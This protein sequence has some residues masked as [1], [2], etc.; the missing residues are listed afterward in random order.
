MEIIA[1]SILNLL[2][3]HR[4]IFSFLGALFEGTYVM[5][6]AGV[7]YKFGYFKLWGVML[8]LL[9]GY[10]LNGIMFYLIGRM[11]GNTALEKWGSRFHLTKK[12][13][14]KLENYFKKHSIKTIF[15]TRITYGL[16]GPTMIIAG[17]FKMKWKKFI[18]VNLISSLVWVLVIFGLGYVFGSSFKALGE[19]TRGIAIGAVV[20][21]FI[22]TVSISVFV[23]FWIKH[24]TKIKFLKRLENN[25]FQFFRKIGNLIN[26]LINKNS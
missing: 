16:S 18:T 3:E 20:A 25:R 10:V 6:L 12:I 19:I 14:E 7:L 11:G 9:G 22:L 17:V 1:N 5:I 23:V 26:N 4:Y 15:V 13:L 8:V 2:Y 21:L 24:F